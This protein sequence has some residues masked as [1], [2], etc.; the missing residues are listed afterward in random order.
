M[1]LHHLKTHLVKTD[2]LAGYVLYSSKL[3]NP[4]I[5]ILAVFRSPGQQRITFIHT[6]FR[7]FHEN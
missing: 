4:Y 7:F 3:G 6:S 1:T 2:L 5:Y